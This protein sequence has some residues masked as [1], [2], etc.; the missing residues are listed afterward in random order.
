MGTNLVWKVTEDFYTFVLQIVSESRKNSCN[1]LPRIIRL[2]RP[3]NHH[4]SALKPANC[5]PNV[6]Q[7][8]RL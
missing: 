1:S 8:F 4:S 6:G 7:K 5:S 3:P 2:A